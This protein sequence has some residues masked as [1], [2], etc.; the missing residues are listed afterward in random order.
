MDDKAPI[1]RGRLA[2]GARQGVL[3]LGLRVQEDREILADRLVA[4]RQ[5][6]LGRRADDHVI[7]LLGRPTEQRVPDRPATATI[8][9]RGLTVADLESAAPDP[10]AFAATDAFV[11]TAAEARAFARAGGL[12]ARALPET[13]GASR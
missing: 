12:A 6:V 13:E 3:G 1:A 5:H 10:T 9:I 11:A 2:L 8:G 7:P 4:S